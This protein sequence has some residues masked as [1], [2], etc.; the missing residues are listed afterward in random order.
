LAAIRATREVAGT[1]TNLG[2]VLLLAPLAAVPADES[3]AEGIHPLLA[4]LTE[5][6]ARQVYE[7]IRFAR[8][9]G[10]GKVPRMDVA[11]SPPGDLLLA[12]REAAGR[13]LV[14][15]Q[16][17][18]GFGQVLGL[19]AP[20][21]VEGRRSGWTLADTIVHVHVRLMASFADSLIAR[22][23]GEELARLASVRATRVLEAG[24]PGEASYLKALSELDLWL[25][26]DHH[27]RNPGTT[28]DLVAAGLFVVLREG[29]IAPPFR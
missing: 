1:N 24:A 17:V 11:G 13:D 18:N 25:R 26:S 3:L 6:D 5:D 4:R 22:K 29:L 9:G 2:T 8:P 19:A 10:L 27:R 7:A 20:W 15:R 12:M 14:A 23:C 16:Y 28:A 21:L